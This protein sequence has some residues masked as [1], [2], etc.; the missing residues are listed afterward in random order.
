MSLTCGIVGLPNVGKSTLF[1][2]LTMSSQAQAENFPFCTIDPNIGKAFVPD[3]RLQVLSGLSSSAKI[4]ASTIDFVD[5]AGLVGG[6]SKGEGLG[7]KFLSHIREVDALVHV[8][9]CFENSQVTHV[10][11]RIDPISDIDTVMTELI[12]ADMESVE[13]RLHSASKK[14]RGGDDE[15]KQLVYN[16][17]KVQEVLEA[18][19]MANKSNIE[20]AELHKLGLL[21]GKPILYVTN[22]DED[23]VMSGNKWSEAVED[24]ARKEK[25]GSFRVSISLES[26]VSQLEE[27]DR[28]EFL[29]EYGLQDSGLVKL[30]RAGYDLLGLMTFFTSGPKETRSWTIKQNTTANRAAGAIHTDF[31][32]G[33]I[34]AETI[35]YEDFVEYGGETGAKEA[36]KRRQEGRDYLVQDGDVIHFR[37][38]V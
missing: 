12:L 22:V 27:D 35:S 20:P 3:K 30:V 14:V 16:M 2:A 36:G 10:S 25:F 23:S 31:E 28:L 21:T 13:R 26:D 37:F 34:C 5:I 4:I 17:S 6:A 29:S 9:R 19:E 38:N 1:N 33:F 18:G 32:R 15:A 24:R 8:V 7:N 11:G